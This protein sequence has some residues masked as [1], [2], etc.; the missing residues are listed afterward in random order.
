MSSP[1]VS[2][3]A[4]AI[5]IG[6]TQ[7]VK[8]GGLPIIHEESLGLIVQ[9]RVNQALEEFQRLGVPITASKHRQGRRLIEAPLEYVQTTINKIEQRKQQGD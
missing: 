1:Q 5:L 4:R 6:I 7:S 9:Q 8:N 2:D 3:A